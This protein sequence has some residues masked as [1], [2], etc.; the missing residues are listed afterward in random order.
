[1]AMLCLALLAGSAQAAVFC[2]NWFASLQSALTTAAGN[3]QGDTMNVVAGTCALGSTTAAGSGNFNRDPQFASG[4][5]NLRPSSISLL[6]NADTLAVAVGTGDYDVSG[7]QR[8]QGAG[9][10]IGAH[11]SECSS[12]MDSN[13]HDIGA[14]C[15][16]PFLP[17]ASL[18][19]CAR[20][21][22]RVWRCRL[23]PG[24]IRRADFR[25]GSAA[26]WCVRRRR[27]RD[28]AGHGGLKSGVGTHLVY[29]SLFRSGGRCPCFVSF[30]CSLSCLSSCLWLN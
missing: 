23:R 27:V 14:T 9:V 22:C 13:C 28:F 20:R 10:D 8:L 5:L 3:G 7:T 1:M 11:E 19:P 15:S 24:A 25:I 6:I 30:W 12:S 29:T 2:V 26:G 17:S 4:F 21:S 18:P 16:K